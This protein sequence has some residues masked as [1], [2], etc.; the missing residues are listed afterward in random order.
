MNDAWTIKGIMRTN[1][2]R[3][4]GKLPVIFNGRKAIF[5]GY[6]KDHHEADALAIKNRLSATYNSRAAIDLEGTEKQFFVLHG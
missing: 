6:A 3:A 2:F 4:D 1:H 5:L